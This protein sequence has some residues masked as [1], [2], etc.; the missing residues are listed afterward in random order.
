MSE[1]ELEFETF[2]DELLILSAHFQVN[3]FIPHGSE[4]QYESAEM[5]KQECL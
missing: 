1:R 5:L 2:T 3:F 4:D